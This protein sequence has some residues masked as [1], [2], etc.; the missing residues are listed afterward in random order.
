VLVRANPPNLH[1][2]VLYISRYRSQSDMMTETGYYMSH[3]IGALHFVKHLTVDMISVDKADFETWQIDPWSTL[4]KRTGLE[5][6]RGEGR[7]SRGIFKMSK[8]WA[9][10]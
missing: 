10:Q 7:N 2:N 5:L 4:V 9:P 6:H 8:T 1:S 3:I